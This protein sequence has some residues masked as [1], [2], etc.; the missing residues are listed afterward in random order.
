MPRRA[1]T[2]KPKRARNLDARGAP[3]AF[4]LLETALA[5]VIVMV[6]VLA[7]MEAQTSFI[8]SNTWSSHE[9][10]ATYLA[11]EI[12]E[13][14][15]QLPRHDP[16]TGLSFQGPPGSQVLVGVGPE[17]GEITV[18]DMDDIDDYNQVLFGLNGT[19]PGPIDAFGT[20]IP[21]IDPDGFVVL[22]AGGQPEPLQ[23]WSQYVEVQKVDPY[24]L[25]NPRAWEDVDNPNLPF[26]GRTVDDFP[27]QVTVTIF[28]QGIYD[29][30]PDIVTRMTW[31][32]PV[33]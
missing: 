29:P 23:G 25:S 2:N 18:G 21:Q 6:G 5:L 20:I 28:Y 32:A 30:A 17:T 10:T 19:H 4:T 12:R 14:L 7:I 16:T 33:R 1:D 27:L 13:R 3:R 8:R 9:A 31:I 24:H 11:S 22:G 26:P 15:R